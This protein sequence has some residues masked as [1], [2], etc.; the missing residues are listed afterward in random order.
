MPDPE[1]RQHPC[2]VKQ[3]PRC[4]LTKR[5]SRFH[6]NRA[7]KDGLQSECKACSKLRCR[8]WRAKNPLILA[9]CNMMN[10]C[11]YP[12]ADSYRYYGARG[13]WVCDEWRN[14]FKAFQNWALA[15]GYAP[16]LQLD[17]IDSDSGYCPQNCR[18][19]TQQE[20][21]RRRRRHVF[22]KAH[23]AALTCAN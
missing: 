10:R 21:L 23:A 18:F 6:R 8:E 19:I 11:Y 1:F 12:R 20:N 14:S 3:C 7:A 5:L 17:R 22:T 9:Y 16:G 2:G 4:K 15:A 13:I